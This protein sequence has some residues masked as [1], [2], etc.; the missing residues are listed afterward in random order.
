[1]S[2]HKNSES[3]AERGGVEARPTDARWWVVKVFL[4][5]AAGYYGVRWLSQ[6][7][8]THAANPAAA[9]EVE[10]GTWVVGV[11]LVGFLVWCFSGSRGG[12]R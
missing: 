4:L 1:M 5:T 8:Q 9:G 11:L 10:L 12:R 6:Y 7:L 2:R 3:G